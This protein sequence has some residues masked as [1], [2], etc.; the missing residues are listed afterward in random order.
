MLYVN[1]KHDFTASATVDQ[2]SPIGSLVIWSHRVQ[3]YDF[4]KSFSCNISFYWAIGPDKNLA[5]KLGN[6]PGKII[7]PRK[8]FT[9][10]TTSVVSI[11]DLK[12]NDRTDGI[13]KLERGWEHEAWLPYFNDFWIWQWEP[14]LSILLTGVPGYRSIHCW[15]PS[16]F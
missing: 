1:Y 15:E 10:A 7:S 14:I 8:W 9:L 2:K 4:P 12:F 6:K 5:W 16:L 13:S 11:L 3:L